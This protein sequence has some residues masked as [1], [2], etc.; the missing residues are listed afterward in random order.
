MACLLYA[1]AYSQSSTFFMKQAAT[2]DRRIGRHFQVPPVALHSF[3]SITIMVIIP[4]YDRVL[5]PVSRRY[6]GKPSGITMLQR[7][8]TGMF[9]SLLSM[10]I[11]A[12][13][14]NRSC[15]LEAATWRLYPSYGRA[16]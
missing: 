14:E 9:L 3:I 16:I 10:V 5:V 4:I 1:V 8:G 12:L 11:A 15:D 6:S 13:V 2:L 7:I